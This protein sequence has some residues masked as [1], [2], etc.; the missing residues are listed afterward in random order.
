MK[1][2]L[3]ELS[4]NDVLAGAANGAVMLS[5]FVARVHGIT[6]PTVVVLDFAGVTV[7]TGS[8]LRE[9]VLGFRD[10]CR[11]SQPNVFP[12]VANLNETVLE[13]LRDLLKFC[14][15]ALIC[16][17]TSGD[18]LKNPRVEGVLEEKQLVALD[19]VLRV[20][21]ADAA[22]LAESFASTEKIGS[23]GWSNRLASLVAEGI[24]MESRSGRTKRYRPVVEGL[25][26]GS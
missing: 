2:S 11:R 20:S 8:Y 14:R 16:C 25:K 15:Q 5:H 1:L 21:E 13:E 19:A 7:A 22:S 18:R 4:R 3:A 17:E 12:V 9:C 6:V 26:L 24:L 10:Y 23:T